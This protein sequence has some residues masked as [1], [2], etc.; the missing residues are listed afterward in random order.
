MTECLLR[1]E[2]EAVLKI[3]ESIGL[4]RNYISMSF[5]SIFRVKGLIWERYVCQTWC[6]HRPESLITRIKNYD[7]LCRCLLL[8]SRRSLHWKRYH[9]SMP[10]LFAV[11]LFPLALVSSECVQNFTAPSTV[12]Q[13]SHHHN[14]ES[15]LD[16]WG[17]SSSRRRTGKRYQLFSDCKF[18]NSKQL[19]TSVTTATT[20][21]HMVTFSARVSL[22]SVLQRERERDTI[23]IKLWRRR[24]EGKGKIMGI[25]GHLKSSSSLLHGTV[26]LGARRTQ[27]YYEGD[28]C[29]GV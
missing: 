13:M 27:V 6:T 1:Y 9:S 18:C 10:V 16:S 2:I 5:A 4:L 23:V 8:A 12:L 26:P 21:M 7:L 20:G 11:K 14:A 19:Y 24:R 22:K 28:Y 3:D 17:S 25:L 29:E 15:G